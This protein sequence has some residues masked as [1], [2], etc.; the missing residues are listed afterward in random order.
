M[1]TTTVDGLWALQVLTGI[2]TIAPELGLRPHLPSVEPK[3]LALQHPVT[4]ELRDVGA[5]EEC[6]AVDPTVV[7]WLTVLSR[8]DVALVLHI[9]TPRDDEPARVLL[10]RFAQ[11]W[12]VLERSADLIRISGA[13]TATAE[14]TADTV[15]N[16]Q[17]ER[18]CGRNEPAPL[19]PVTLDAGAMRSAAAGQEALQTFLAGQR[20]DADQLRLLTLAADPDRSAQASVVAAQ[21]GVETGRFQRTHVEAGAVTIIDTLE[22]RLVA[23]EVDHGGTTWMIIAPGTRSNIAAAIN[24]MMRRLPAHQDWH[25]YRK[26]V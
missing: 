16:Q 13:G 24:R 2:E 3:Q 6:G 8:R 1:L 18:L 15:L 9:R 22:G 4:A 19:R 12:V 7:E 20:V 26:V 14:G 17:I 25:S 23:E 21:S 10:A 5:V 11:W